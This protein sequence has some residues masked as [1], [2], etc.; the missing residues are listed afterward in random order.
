MS[1]IFDAMKK[2]EAERSGRDLADVAPP[3]LPHA[4]ERQ[5]VAARSVE[6]AGEIATDFS[7]IMQSEIGLQPLQETE[8]EGVQLKPAK[9]ELEERKT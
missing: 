7:S 3:D 4:V 5:A 6:S 9:L 8:G 1:H 2:S